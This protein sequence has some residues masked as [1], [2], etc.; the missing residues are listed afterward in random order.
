MNTDNPRV[1]MIMGAGAVLDMNF[2]CGMVVP[3]TWNITEEVRK[4][5][6]DTFNKDTKITIVN[7]IYEVLR[8]KLPADLNIWWVENSQPNI[9]FEIL[10]HVLEQLKAYDSAWN[11]NNHNPHSFPYFAPFTSANFSF[12][13]SDLYQVMPQFILRIME[14]VNAYDVYFK[15]DNKNEDWYREF[16]KSDF[17]WD[18]FNLN[19]DTTVEEC[20]DKYEDGFEHIE[21]R[22]EA[23]FRPQKLLLNS[24]KLSTI[25]HIH[26]CVNYYY[27]NDANDDL[28][29]TNIHDLYLYPSFN[30]VKCRLPGR[31][32]SNPSSQ[33]N[34]E[35]LAGPIITGLRKTEKLMCMPYDFYH[36]N[37]YKAIVSSN[38]LVIVGYSFGDLYINNL[39]NR[40]HAVWKGAER[41]VVIDK[42]DG[43][44]IMGYKNQLIKYLETLPKGEIEFLLMMSGCECIGQM[45][46]EFIDPDIFHPKYS[47]NKSLMLITSGM[48][49]ASSIQDD[50]HTFLM[51]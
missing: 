16:F 43:R 41:I 11:V 7:D 39:I 27:K 42:W 18:V 2:P 36:A 28:F 6:D 45:V 4:P 32:Q 23:I 47:K 34:E 1:T 20:L 25:N 5:Y 30:D 50:I 44:R 8:E 10:F 38:A 49:V 33:N 13:S 29:D 51:S 22:T 35:Y 19:Y 3:T 15:Y 17:K 48:K 37:L 9:H 26:G 40:M 46:N 14:I 21:G 24:E 12:N 31:G